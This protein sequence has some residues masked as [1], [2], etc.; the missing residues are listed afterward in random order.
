MPAFVPPHAAF[1]W[2][3]RQ[4]RPS[5]RVLPERLNSALPGGRAPVA[6]WIEERFTLLILESGAVKLGNAEGSS[7]AANALFTFIAG[8]SEPFILGLVQRIA[9]V[10][11][12]DATLSQRQAP[13]R[14]W[15]R[16]D[17]KVGVLAGRRL[18]VGSSS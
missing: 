9:V 17:S 7:W 18:G 1:S 6:Q 11:D 13:I 10:P 12:K 16:C 14:T 4:H 8:F 15:P 2:G 3:F 5:L